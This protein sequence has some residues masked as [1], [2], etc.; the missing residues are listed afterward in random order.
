MYLAHSFVESSEMKNIYDGV[1]ELNDRSEAV[2]ELPRW[3]D[4]LNG[5]F[6]YQLTPIGTPGPELQ[7]A[8]ELADK[9]FRIAGGSPGL[10]VSWQVTGVRKDPGQSPT[11]SELR[12]TSKTV[13][14]TII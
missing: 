4:A 1:V 10:K 13:S 6:R 2:V 14:G 11:Q 3:F 8:K 12:K 5:D 9:N 7:I